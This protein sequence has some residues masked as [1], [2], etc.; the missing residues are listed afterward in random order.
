MAKKPARN[1]NTEAR[2]GRES[3]VQPATAPPRPDPK[4]AT[5]H[6]IELRPGL[7]LNPDHIVSVRVLAQEQDG[8]YAIVQL[9]SGEIQNLTREEF[10]AVT[11][12]DP[13]PPVQVPENLQWEWKGKE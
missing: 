8:I 9:S 7:F 10:T 11:G 5:P 12:E 2:R 6:L 13:R 4:A 3:S 1:G